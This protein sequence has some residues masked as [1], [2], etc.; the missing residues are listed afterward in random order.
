M[1]FFLWNQILGHVIEKVGKYYLEH[2]LIL[3]FMYFCHELPCYFKVYNLHKNVYMY[4]YK[5]QTIISIILNYR[6]M[7]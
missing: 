7:N 4:I 6:S 1:F 3:S 5:L 2:K